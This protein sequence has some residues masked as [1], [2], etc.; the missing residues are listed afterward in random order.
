MGHLG[1]LDLAFTFHELLPDD[2]AGLVPGDGIWSAAPPTNLTESDFNPA[3][4]QVTR[5]GQLGRLHPCTAAGRLFCFYLVLGS[6][7]ALASL[8]PLNRML[9][10][11]Q[12]TAATDAAVDL[13]VAGD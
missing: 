4:L 1:P 12:A 5:P 13:N 2:G 11:F 9:G 7:A 8:D 3:T 6:K 10:S